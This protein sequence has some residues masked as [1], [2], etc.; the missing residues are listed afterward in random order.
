MTTFEEAKR[1][2]KCEQP[3]RE[4]SAHHGSYGSTMY[5][6]ECANKRCPWYNTSYIVQVN[7]DG[8]I[9][10]PS[11]DRPHQFPKLPGQSEIDPEAL[12]RRIQNMYIQTRPDLRGE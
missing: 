10:E 2:P 5:V 7:A 9:P 4:T 8:T 6:I 3:G 1:C 12:E 11:N